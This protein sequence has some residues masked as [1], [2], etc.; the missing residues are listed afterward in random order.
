MMRIVAIAA[1]PQ[2]EGSRVHR[3]WVKGLEESNRVSVRPLYQFYANWKID[4]ALEQ[5]TLAAHDRIVLQF[6]FFLYGCP[7]LMKKWLDEV[8]SFQWAYGPGGEALRGKQMLIAISTG[9]PPE[10]Y[11]HGGFHNFTI[12][13]LLVPFRQIANLVGADYVRPFVFH[14]ARTVSDAEI[15]ASAAE[16]VRYVLNPNLE[17]RPGP[18]AGR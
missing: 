17:I 1:H 13:E 11:R 14:R 2:I 9:G 18:S 12:D 6:P 8:M 4:A 7:P 16:Y 3:A 15:T 5:R 10:S